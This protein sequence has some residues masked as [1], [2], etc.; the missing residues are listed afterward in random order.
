MGITN[1]FG[2]NGLDKVRGRILYHITPD[3]MKQ[4]EDFSQQGSHAEILGILAEKQGSATFQEISDRIHLPPKTVA[5]LLN[6]MCY[7]RWI[8]RT[9]GPGQGMMPAGYPQGGMQQR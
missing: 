9:G 3:G 2:R 1:L 7:R 4:V 5:E 6:D 8:T